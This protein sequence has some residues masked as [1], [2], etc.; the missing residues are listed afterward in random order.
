[1]QGGVDAEIAV[2]GK[3]HTAQIKPFTGYDETEDKFVVY[4]TANVK[5][6]K[7]DWIIFTNKSDQMLIFKN[8]NTK[9]TSGNYSFPKETLIK[10]VD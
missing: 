2:D 6:Y 5:P 8:S 4:G 7:T 10:K 1:M 9:I 3:K